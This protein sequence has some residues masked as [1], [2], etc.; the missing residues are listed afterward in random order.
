MPMVNGL[1]TMKPL[2]A[3]VQAPDF[4]LKDTHG[5][6]HSLGRET[7]KGTAILVFYKSACPTSQFTFPYIQKIFAA[8]GE[9]G[10]C[11]LWAISQDELND[12]REFAAGFGFTFL[13]DEHPYAVSSAY[14][15]ANVPS[16]FIVEAG[17]LI[18]LSD[19]G[20]SK[21]T[22]EEMS[23][24][25]AKCA[26]RPPVQLFRPDDGLPATRPG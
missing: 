9:T 12:T 21:A 16:V 22:L 4:E 14:G 11:T 5:N 1:Y 13:I 15:L 25:M 2:C 3:G 26:G 20:F 17:G 10:G 6:S 8:M 24:R 19:F 23:T 18:S 7:A